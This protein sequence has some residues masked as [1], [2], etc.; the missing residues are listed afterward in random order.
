MKHRNQKGS[1][2]PVARADGI[3]V[4]LYRWRER[5]Q[6]GT[7]HPRKQTIGALEDLP[8][9][10][11]TWETVEALK[12]NINFDPS[13]NGRPRLFRELV[14]HSTKNELQDKDNEHK[15]FST[16]EGYKVYLSH[17]IVPK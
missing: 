15:S 1:L 2:K 3:R 10:A 13:P 11:K 7:L 4:W 6:D 5:W 8:T 12:L 9:R 16:R 17:H 14:E